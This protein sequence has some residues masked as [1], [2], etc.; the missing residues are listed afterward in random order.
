LAHKNHTFPASGACLLD[1]PIRKLTQLSSELIKK[2]SITQD[3]T[4]MYFG[5][6]PGYST[7]ELAK[8]VGNVIAVDLSVDRLNIAKA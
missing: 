7:V 2:M 4:V 8:K 6:G 1:N 5:C 3:Q